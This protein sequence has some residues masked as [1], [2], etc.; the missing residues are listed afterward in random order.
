LVDLN[1]EALRIVTEGRRPTEIVVREDHSLTLIGEDRDRP[2]LTITTAFGTLPVRI[3]GNVGPGWRMVSDEG[4]IGPEGILSK[5]ALKERILTVLE[6]QM[7]PGSAA[8]L[9]EAYRG[10]AAEQASK[11]V[12]D[13]F[14]QQ[15]IVT[16]PLIGRLPVGRSLGRAMLLSMVRDDVSVGDL[17]QAFR[18]IEAEARGER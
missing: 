1:T 10:E 12:L 14:T 4:E 18:E 13:H 6:T 3:A 2:G 5:P 11:I 9:L 7:E 15:G 17:Q 16:E 8:Q